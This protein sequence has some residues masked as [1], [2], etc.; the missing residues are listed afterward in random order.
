MSRRFE[1]SGTTTRDTVPKGGEMPYRLIKGSFH[2]FYSGADDRHVGAQ[3]D[4]DSAWFRPNHPQHL[5]D[6]DGRSAEFNKGGFCQLRFE[7]I[8]ALELHFQGAKQNH[9]ASVAARRF[10]VT[11]LG[12]HA[13][14]YSDG[15]G[16]AVRTAS[17]H[18]RVGHILTRTVDPYGRPV[19]FVFSGATSR[20]DGSEVWLDTAMLNTTVNARLAQS[21]NTYPSFYS[22][23]PRD[24]R[25]RVA[26]LADSAWQAGRGLWPHDKTM[27]GVR[28]TDLSDLQALAVWPKLFR[29]LVKYF[30]E[31]N[32]GLA[33]F[34][35]WLRADSDRDD[36]LWIISEGTLGNL[37]DVLEI[38]GN[39]LAMKY[40]PEDLVIVP[41]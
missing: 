37:H 39:Q 38:A 21:G 6:L 1:Q 7:A 30:R 40:W 17:P 12:F 2:L 31:G 36:E 15:K 10:L 14:T 25:D 11:E 41:R 35:T 9:T 34:D 33:G 27:S 8:D 4:G 3:P 22:G 19:S 26:E 32:D 20:A 24:L 16:L 23:L 13:V 28:I 29:R 18:P 5:V